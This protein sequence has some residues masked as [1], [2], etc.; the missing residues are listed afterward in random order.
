MAR[1]TKPLPFFQ[2]CFDE[3]KACYESGVTS[4]DAASAARPYRL[5]GA[6]VEHAM[7]VSW[8]KGWN[9]AQEAAR[10]A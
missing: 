9:A 2:D 3:G 5:F 4:V 10:K 1:R 7:A 6:V 8:G